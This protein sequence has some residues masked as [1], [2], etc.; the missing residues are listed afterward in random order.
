MIMGVPDASFPFPF[1][2]LNGVR[3]AINAADPVTVAKSNMHLREVLSNTHLPKADDEKDSSSPCPTHRNNGEVEGRHN[4]LSIG[5]DEDA[6][7]SS[8]SSS[9]VIYGL[10]NN[11]QEELEK[12]QEEEGYMKVGSGQRSGEYTPL[13]ML[14]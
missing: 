2:N 13:N 3:L 10:N 1:A 6:L 5:N 8:S 9:S 11:H 7:L 4:T 12:I 14:V